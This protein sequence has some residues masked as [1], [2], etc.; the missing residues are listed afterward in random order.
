MGYIDCP[1]CGQTKAMR[2]THDKNGEPFGYCE[3][4]C[5]Q[6]L[7]IGGNANRVKLFIERYPFAAKKNQPN[8][9]AGDAEPEK[10]QTADHLKILGID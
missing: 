7:R 4:E 6:Q 1:T 8:A 10:Q 5:S 9:Q 2:I 3:T